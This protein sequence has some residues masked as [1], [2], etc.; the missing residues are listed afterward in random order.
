[1][2]YCN[3]KKKCVRTFHNST[4]TVSEKKK[5]ITKSHLYIHEPCKVK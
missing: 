4:T 5:S 1:M 2:F 3:W